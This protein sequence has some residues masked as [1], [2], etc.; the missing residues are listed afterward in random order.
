MGFPQEI[1]FT[2]S[3]SLIMPLPNPHEFRDALLK[4]KSE[5]V[6]WGEL[7]WCIANDYDPPFPEA[8]IS[9]ADF[10]QSLKFVR[11]SQLILLLSKW[12]F[13]FTDT[14][15]DCA[16]KLDVK[17]WQVVEFV[18]N[19][20]EMLDINENDLEV[21][22]AFTSS[23]IKEIRNKTKADSITEVSPQDSTNLPSLSPPKNNRTFTTQIVDPSDL[24]P[25]RS[26]HQS[27]LS[28]SSE[29]SNRRNPTPV[30]EFRNPQRENLITEKTN[31][32]VKTLVIILGFATALAWVL[33]YSLV[34]RHNPSADAAS[35]VSGQLSNGNG[36]SSQA[37]QES[38]GSDI[39]EPCKAN[40]FQ[41]TVQARSGETW[42]PVVGPPASL[43]IVLSQCRGD[44]FIN[45]SGNVQV[46]SFSDRDTARSFA[47][48]ITGVSTHTFQFW[49][50][51]PTFR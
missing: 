16:Q 47:E 27:K 32:T 49:V 5:G 10:Q 28:T 9:D 3:T 14:T 12:D 31:L 30:E 50:G 35:S 51:E 4:I 36:N 7:F 38:S 17:T 40:E 21:S 6:S 8:V 2:F 41:S 18:E 45:K 33:Y 29:A 11:S 1:L 15:D 46:A 25:G 23:F 42:W 19:T 22:N 44:A 24:D 39:W 13:H 34:Q 20:R 48:R 26:T 43:D 37:M